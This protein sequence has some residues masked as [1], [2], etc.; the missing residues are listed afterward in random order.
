MFDAKRVVPLLEKQYVELLATKGVRLDRR[1]REC[2]NGLAQFPSNH[3]ILNYPVE[4]L[5]R[6]SNIYGKAGLHERIWLKIKQYTQGRPSRA[7]IFKDTHLH[8]VGV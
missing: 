1:L 6:M 4:Y 8:F 3:D 5:Q 2:Y 7:Y